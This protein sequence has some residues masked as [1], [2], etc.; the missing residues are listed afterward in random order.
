[1]SVN[2]GTLPQPGHPRDKAQTS[3]T[4][5]AILGRL[6]TMKV[7]PGSIHLSWKVEPSSIHPI[8]NCWEKWD[9]VPFTSAGKWDPVP[10]TR[11]QIAGKSGTR[12]HSPLLENGT[13]FHP[14]H[15]K[16]LGK[17]GPGSIHLSEL[18]HVY[19]RLSTLESDSIEL[20]VTH[21]ERDQDLLQVHHRPVSLIYSEWVCIHYGVC[22]VWYRCS[23]SE[24][25]SELRV[26]RVTLLAELCKKT[27]L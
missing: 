14:P 12:F 1:M 10:S 18:F 15:S 8:A 23:V 22:C 27:G 25:C 17:V 16:L 21:S 7:G 4:V 2:S 13:R 26:Q 6:A 9:P 5:P 11:Q 20:V 24:L 3:G 19:C